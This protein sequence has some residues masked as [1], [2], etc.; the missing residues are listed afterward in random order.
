MKIGST[1]NRTMLVTTRSAR[2]LLNKMKTYNLIKIYSAYDVSSIIA[3]D[4][5]ITVLEKECIK[6]EL[7][8]CETVEKINCEEESILHIYVDLY[9]RKDLGGLYIGLAVKKKLLKWNRGH[10]SNKSG[11]ADEDASEIEGNR[12]GRREFCRRIPLM[13][14][15]L[16]EVTDAPMMLLFYPVNTTSADVMMTHTQS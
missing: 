11:R 10:E 12:A 15:I 6:Y 4:L 1:D 3:T 8:V 13:K 2:V 14:L 5:L 7:A 16:T 9:P